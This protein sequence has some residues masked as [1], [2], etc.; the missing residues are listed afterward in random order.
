MS[1]LFCDLVAPSVLLTGKLYDLLGGRTAFV[2]A[3]TANRS[4]GP[5]SRAGFE[6]R[7]DATG[8]KLPNDEILRASMVAYVLGKI[9]M[10]DIR[11]MDGGLAEWRKRTLPKTQEY[12]GNPLGKLPERGACCVSTF[13]LSHVA[14]YPNVRLYEGS[15][16]EYASLKKYMAETKENKVK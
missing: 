5:L 8:D 2:S 16:K 13:Y 11:I 9:G 10:K 4:L 1:T 14:G 15:W 12:F 3:E 6:R 7:T